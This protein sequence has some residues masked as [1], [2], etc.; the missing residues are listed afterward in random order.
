MKDK[1]EINVSQRTIKREEKG[2]KGDVMAM[3]EWR[4]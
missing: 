3:C 4:M 2:K 1:L